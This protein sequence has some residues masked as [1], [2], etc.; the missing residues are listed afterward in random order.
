[1]SHIKTGKFLVV[2]IAVALVLA[3]P[4]HAG[5]VTEVFGTTTP[6]SLQATDWFNQLVFPQFDP[7][8][9]TLQSVELDLR[10]SWDT[11]LTVTNNYSGTTSGNAR[12]ELDFFI[13]DT[14]SYSVTSQV[15][16]VSGSNLT[17]Q[18]PTYDLLSTAM[19]YVLTGSGTTATASYSHSNS[20]FDD[21]YTTTTPTILSEFTQGGGTI[22]LN[23]RTLTNTVNIFGAGDSTAAQV[24]SASLTGT[25]SYTYETTSTPEPASLGLIG[26][27]LV[28]LGFW[29]RRRT[30][31][32]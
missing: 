18:E 10:A 30:K 25:V 16:T 21:V 5:I 13:Y 32:V 2:A 24:T 11:L 7:T 31:R 20:L 4:A 9:G 1:M 23:A 17:S 29:A 22:S 28:G 6:I 8:L 26:I 27:G 19:P 12:T 14:G 15:G 3:M